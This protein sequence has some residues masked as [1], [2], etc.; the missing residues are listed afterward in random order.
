MEI[1]YDI[2]IKYLSNDTTKTNI[3][4][5]KKH[6][7]TY[8]D[9]FPN[10]FIEILQNKFYKYGI[11]IV[12]NNNINISFY[13]SLLTLL[14]KKFISF[15]QDEE[16]NYINNFKNFI[17]EKIKTFI[18]SENLKLYLEKNKLNKK[19][20]SNNIDVYYIQTIVE[21]LDINLLILD[22]LNNE[23]FIVYPDAECNPWKPTIIL[24]NYNNFWEP[25]IYDIKSKRTFN[26]NDIYLKKILYETDIKY[27]NSKLINKYFILNDNLKEIV[28]KIIPDETTKSL[29]TFVKINTQSYDTTTLNKITKAELS[30]ICKLKNLKINTKMVKKELIDLILNN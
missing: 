6:I 26:I 21:I 18:P 2:I 13:S 7:L 19:D 24:A 16:I 11:T 4:T 3:F 12:D 9:K 1:N 17:N 23:I 15:T 30:D 27:Y 29:D 5:N 22:F 14:N 8:S 20:L 28:N 25:I 10:K